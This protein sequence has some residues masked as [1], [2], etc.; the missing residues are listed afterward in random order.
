M[1]IF[2]TRALVVAGGAVF[3][4]NRFAWPKQRKVVPLEKEKNDI[5]RDLQRGLA[6][7]AVDALVFAFMV[8]TGLLAGQRQSSPL[9]FWATFAAM[10]VL[11]SGASPGG[12]G[13]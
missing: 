12:P 4:T 5:G 3:W 2:T 6:V 10:F 11:P 1:G 8:Q 7:L 9:G 13:C